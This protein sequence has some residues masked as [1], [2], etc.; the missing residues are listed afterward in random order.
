MLQL[1][2]LHILGIM[3]VWVFN[4]NLWLFFS[5]TCLQCLIILIVVHVG[6]L[7]LIIIR[8]VDNFDF[9][10]CRVYLLHLNLRWWNIPRTFLIRGLIIFCM[11][12]LWT[13]SGLHVLD[14]RLNSMYNLFVLLSFKQFMDFCY[15]RFTLFVLLISLMTLMAFQRQKFPNFVQLTFEKDLILILYKFLILRR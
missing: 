11:L 7:V 3:I 12:Q 9:I 4:L 6:I 14:Q 15:Q 8:K 2:D 10:R 13:W 1:L 5:N